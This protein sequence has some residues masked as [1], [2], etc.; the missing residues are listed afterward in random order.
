M[1]RHHPQTKYVKHMVDQGEVGKVQLIRGSFCYTNTRSDNPRINLE[2]GGG[3]LW[4]VGCYPI[5]YAGYLTGEN[6]IEVYGHQITG[7]SGIDLFYA[8]QLR[9]PGGVISQFECSFISP[10]KALIEI[11]GEE[12]RITIP[13]PYKPGK[14]TKIYV[15][16]GG[17]PRRVEIKGAELYRGEVE[18]IE[19]AVL[20]GSSTLISL[21]ESQGII[22]TI[23]ALYQSPKL[24][25]PIMIQNL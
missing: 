11:T 6:P 20:F 2:L 19:R 15:E 12:G 21:D 1:Y 10:D 24:S 23:E 9:F 18:D 3:S 25:K 22:T 13:E 17:R 16:R 7:S 14:K 5:S 4:D 8:G